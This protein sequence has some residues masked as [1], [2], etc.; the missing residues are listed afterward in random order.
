MIARVSYSYNSNFEA[1]GLPGYFLDAYVAKGGELLVD[2]HAVYE[3]RQE[4]FDAIGEIIPVLD[5][6]RAEIDQT[7]R[8]VGVNA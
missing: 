6:H 2:V 3:T 1:A 4:F 8:G 7:T 5:E